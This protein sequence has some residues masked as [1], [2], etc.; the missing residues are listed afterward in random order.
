MEPVRQGLMTLHTLLPHARLSEGQSPLEANREWYRGQWIDCR[1]TVNQWLEA[2]VVE[3]VNPQDILPPRQTNT[4][5]TETQTIANRRRRLPYVASD[6][7][8]SAHDLEGRRKLLMEP[9]EPGDLEEEEG[10]VSGFRQRDNNEGIQL[11]LIHY[12]G[13]PHRWDE[14]IRS[15]A[16]RIR[17]FRTRTRHPSVVRKINA[18][19]TTK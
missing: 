17:P 7:A 10:V 11:L 3:I 13:W 16:E 12:N 4:E 6:P 15:D 14:W 1:D 9:C 18:I 8:V 19:S 5:Q 2:T